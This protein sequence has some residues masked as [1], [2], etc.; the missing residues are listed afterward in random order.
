MA[1]NVSISY[2]QSV[3]SGTLNAVAE[4]VSLHPKLATYLVFVHD[5]RGN[6]IALSQGTVYRKNESLPRVG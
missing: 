4:E 2:F 3:S 1:I 6:K 5:D